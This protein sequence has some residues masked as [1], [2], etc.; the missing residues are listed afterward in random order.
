MDRKLSH[1]NKLTLS[2]PS[3][4]EVLGDGKCIEKSKWEMEFCYC[5]IDK[6]RTS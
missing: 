5:F 3:D 1:E 4:M 2:W 6:S